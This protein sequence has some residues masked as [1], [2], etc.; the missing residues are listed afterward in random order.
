MEAENNQVTTDGEGQPAVSETGEA[1]GHTSYYVHRTRLYTGIG[2]LLIL[3]ALFIAGS[4]IT[5]VLRDT[6]IAL[7]VVSVFGAVLLYLVTPER[8]LAAGLIRSIEATGSRNIQSLIERAGV[9]RTPRYVP[10]ETG[11]KLV[12]PELASDPTPP[13]AELEKEY[14][15]RDSGALV[16]HPSGERVLTES[17]F[18][19]GDVRPDKT[20][21]IDALS[22][23]IIR[24][25]G[26]ANRTAIESIDDQH[27]TV[28][29]T[30]S[31]F[32]ATHHLDH[33]VQSI[34]AVGLATILESPVQPT[35]TVKENDDLLITFR[36]GK[37]LGD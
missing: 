15:E 9:A 11:V 26:L 30:G 5:P 4:F 34:F 23:S 32:D 1:V 22:S 2:L 21:A 24:Q 20:A 13:V 16:L 28:K 37:K 33:P 36:W 27:A 29:I 7:S 35:M 25:R 3:A 14:S 8:F 10:T 17:G 6:L 12:F 18:Q 31:V 19:T